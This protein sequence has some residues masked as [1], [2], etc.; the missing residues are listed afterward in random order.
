ML[1]KIKNRYSDEQLDL[2]KACTLLDVQYK[3]DPFVSDGWP[4]LMQEVREVCEQEKSQHQVSDFYRSSN[5][6]HAFRN[7]I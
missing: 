5:N 1:K 7:F 3:S 4:Y 6:V 2:L